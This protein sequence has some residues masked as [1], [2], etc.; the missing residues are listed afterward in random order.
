MPSWTRA[1]IIDLGNDEG[2]SGQA[3]KGH[4]G[5]D[6]NAKPI[7]DQIIESPVIAAVRD[8]VNLE[9]ALA[10]PVRIIFLLASSINQV[11]WQCDLIREKGKTCFLHVDLVGGLRPDQQGMRFIA[12]KI[13]PNGI[14]TT[15]A[16]C[17]RW[18]QNHHLAT[19]QRIFLLDSQALRDG[20]SNIRAARPDLVEILPGLSEKA[21]QLAVSSFDRPLIAGGL[22]RSREDVYTAL[23]A[24]AI[25]VSTGEASLWQL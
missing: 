22:I 6:I 12:E 7:V 21:I 25:G 14:I 18:A 4:S 9:Q 20:I 17:V 10:A 16:A 19:V 13:K 8:G 2:R 11:G 1:L 23:S 24:G 5:M 15:K 3:G